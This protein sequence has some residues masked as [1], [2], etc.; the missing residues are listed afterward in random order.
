M[1]IRDSA[2]GIGTVTFYSADGASFAALGHGI[3]D[4]DTKDVLAIR[5]GEP[6]AISIC[7]IEPGRTG[8]PAAC[9]DIF[10]RRRQP[11]HAYAEHR[12]RHLRHAEKRCTA[13]RWSRCSTARPCT[14]VL[15]RSRR[16]SMKTACSFR[17]GDRAREHGRAAG[18]KDARRSRGRIPTRFAETGGIVQGMSGC[19][20]LQDGKPRRRGDACFCG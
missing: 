11:R 4:S 9:A 19:P 17:R 6:A 12:T 3:C 5:T 18:D 20:I 7:G 10:H 14:L 16:R 8:E 2:A 13:G 1:W 15:C